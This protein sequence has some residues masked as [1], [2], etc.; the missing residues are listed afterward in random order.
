M[1]APPNDTDLSSLE[2][3]NRYRARLF[4]SREKL[5]EHVTLAQKDLEGRISWVEFDAS[6]HS[7][8][9]K[10]ALAIFDKPPLP[11]AKRALFTFIL[12]VLNLEPV[13][14]FFAQKPAAEKP[15]GTTAPIPDPMGRKCEMCG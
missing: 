15:H 11:M 3:P 4:V 14:P 5:L 13:E 12:E 1:S 9:V 6:F 8:M 10:V 7:H 2:L